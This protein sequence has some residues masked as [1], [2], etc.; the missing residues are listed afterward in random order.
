MRGT[1]TVVPIVVTVAIALA[2]CGSDA[3][4]DAD[5]EGS[6]PPTSSSTP[7]PTPPEPSPPEPSP[8]EPSP[9]E[10]SP[11][12]PSDQPTRIGV[13]ELVGVPQPGVEGGCWLIDEY[14]LLGGDETLLSSGRRLR[15]TGHVERGVM[16]TCQQ[17][18][19]FRVESVEPVD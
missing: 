10:P 8:P 5:G 13:G 6:A 18:I 14:L 12:E 9:P 1:R 2:G 11:P 7:E 17:G 15:V 4:G 19:A 16:T 3:G